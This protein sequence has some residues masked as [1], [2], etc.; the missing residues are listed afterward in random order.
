MTLACPGSDYQSIVVEPFTWKAFWEFV[1]SEPEPCECRNDAN[2]GRGDNGHAHGE[3]SECTCQDCW[4]RRGARRNA[5]ILVSEMVARKD[6]EAVRKAADPLAPLPPDPGERIR[7]RMLQFAA[8]E[9]QANWRGLMAAARERW[10]FTTDEGNAFRAA[11]EAK[12]AEREAR[13]QRDWQEHCRRLDEIRR[14]HRQNG[15]P[16][17]IVTSGDAVKDIRR[18]AAKHTADDELAE[19]YDVLLAH[20]GALVHLRGNEDCADDLHVRLRAEDPEMHYCDAFCGGSFLLVA[21]RTWRQLLDILGRTSDGDIWRLINDDLDWEQIELSP[22]AA[23]VALESPDWPGVKILKGFQQLP[24][25]RLDGTLVSDPGWDAASG[26]WAVAPM[27][28]AQPQL[29]E[30][31]AGKLQVLCMGADGTWRGSM[32]DLLVALQAIWDA[33]LHWSAKTLS[34]ELN[35]S[36][37]ELTDHGID[38]GKTRKRV[39]PKRREEWFVT[40]RNLPILPPLAPPR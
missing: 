21:V 18:L 16:S 26:L 9:A 7:R 32:T 29:D 3:C 40:A 34:G 30:G 10:L 2:K 27:T 6:D 28:P 23:R 8:Q 12:E 24:F 25:L 31:L 1:T 11:E 36:R 20:K 4:Y 39:G 35:R 14:K 13:E 17:G 22:E 33:A 19:Y 15:P 5:R 37:A 38:F